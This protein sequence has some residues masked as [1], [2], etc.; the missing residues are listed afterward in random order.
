MENQFQEISAHSLL[1]LFET[2]KEQRRSFIEQLVNAIENGDVSALKI[3][4]QIK[5]LEDIITSLT[6]RDAKKNKGSIELANTYWK[7]LLD[8]GGKYGKEFELHNSKFTTKEV[9]IKYNYSVCNDVE[10]NDLMQEV[11]ELSE[12]VKARE[13]YLKHIPAKG[14]TTVNE[15]TGEAT[16]IYPPSKSSTTSIS[17]TLK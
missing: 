15:E 4:L 8:E 1:S 11:Q 5:C 17:V 12:K 16:T 6:S 2:T 14:I 13:E 10:Y 9:G 3:H 7:S